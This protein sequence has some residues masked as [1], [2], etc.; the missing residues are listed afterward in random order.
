VAFTI[1]SQQLALVVGDDGKREVRPGSLQIRVRG[2]S[3]TGPATLVRTTT[4][5]GSPLAPKYHFV[6]PAVN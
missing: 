2:S 5:E 3:A 4:R 1:T 6:T